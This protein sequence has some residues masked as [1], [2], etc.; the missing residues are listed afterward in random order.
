MG[1]FTGASGS[2]P[3]GMTRK[4]ASGEECENYVL[5]SIVLLRNHKICVRNYHLENCL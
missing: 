2:D 5:G 1:F 3:S 4:G